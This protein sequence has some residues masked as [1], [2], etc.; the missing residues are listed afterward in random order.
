M[1]TTAQTQH[2]L[3]GNTTCCCACLWISSLDVAHE[4]DAPSS[5]HAPL[6]QAQPGK[7]VLRGVLLLSIAGPM[8]KF[9]NHSA[10]R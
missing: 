2:I 6:L 4:L 7:L 1:Y 5:R 3:A 9:K 10:V 8:H